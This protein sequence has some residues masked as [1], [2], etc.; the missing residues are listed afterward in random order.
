[1]RLRP[2]MFNKKGHHQRSISDFSGSLDFITE[3]AGIKESRISF[4]SEIQQILVY[5]R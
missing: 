2:V 5:D 3:L 4:C 1:M